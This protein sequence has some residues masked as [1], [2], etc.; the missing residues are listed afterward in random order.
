MYLTHEN[1]LFGF[2]PLQNNMLEVVLQV[3]VNRGLVI[4]PAGLP[5]FERAPDLQ[6]NEPV[7]IG[8]CVLLSIP[9]LHVQLRTHD[10]FMG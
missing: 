6:E 3:E 10:Y 2:I 4:L 9:S 8:A 5:G 7:G 1:L